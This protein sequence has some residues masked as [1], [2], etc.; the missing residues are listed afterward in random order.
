MHPT[1]TLTSMLEEL[2][3]YYQKSYLNPTTHKKPHQSEEDGDPDYHPSRADSRQNNASSLP[4]ISK[5]SVIQ[6]LYSNIRNA[7]HILCA[8]YTV[9]HKISNEINSHM[10]EEYQLRIKDAIRR[11]NNY[12][13]FQGKVKISP[14]KKKAESQMGRAVSQSLLIDQDKQRIRFI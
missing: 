9:H 7:N 2:K 13:R 14:S 4:R 8:N 5:I 11:R 1:L 10:V 3:S 6:P 12:S